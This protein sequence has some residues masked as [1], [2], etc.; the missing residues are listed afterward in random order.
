M[1][2]AGM[3]DLQ[4]TYQIITHKSEIVLVLSAPL[5][6]LSFTPTQA[7]ELARTLLNLADVLEPQPTAKPN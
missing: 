4:V 2:G 5:T 7:R 3:T 6:T 1:G